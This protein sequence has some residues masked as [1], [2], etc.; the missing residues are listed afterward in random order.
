MGSVK[1]EVEQLRTINIL[2]Q[3]LEQELEKLSNEETAYLLEAHAETTNIPSCIR[4]GLQASKEL[5]K[6]AENSV[7]NFFDQVTM[8]EAIALYK[9]EKEVFRI[10]D[11]NTESLI[12]FESE[13]GEGIVEGC[14]FGTEKRR[15]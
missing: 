5:V 10:F 14:L 1:P 11:D 13:I 8:D 7:W 4:W 6:E 2:F 12:E 3:L 15:R 9:N